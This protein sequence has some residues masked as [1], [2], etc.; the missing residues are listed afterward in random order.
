[1]EQWC[2]QKNLERE[3]EIG[4][5]L[6]QAPSNGE[7]ALLSETAAISFACLEDDSLALL[8]LDLDSFKPINDNYGHQK[9]DQVLRELSDLFRSIVREKDI[10]ARYGGDEFLVVA[11]ATSP[12]EAVALAT[13]LQ[14]AVERYNPGL[15]HSEL[16]ALRLGVSIGYACYP[17]DG[18]DYPSLLAIADT[19]M[20]SNKTERKLRH[21]AQGQS[22]TASPPE[23]APQTTVTSRSEIAEALPIFEAEVI[24]VHPRSA[25]E[26][27]V[28]P[29]PVCEGV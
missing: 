4:L 5:R 22:A 18:S 25:Q 6:N 27:A 11:K 26:T 2:T 21:L 24:L 13:R 15:M 9:G 28:T 29:S 12:T 20:Y 23:T 10:L 19:R 14:E 1:M 3:A 8:C 7:D 17:I 16:G